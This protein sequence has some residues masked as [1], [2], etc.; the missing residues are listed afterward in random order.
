MKNNNL[1]SS[2]LEKL[3]HKQYFELIRRHGHTMAKEVCLM[4]NQTGNSMQQS[5]CSDN[6]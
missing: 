2:Y 6:Q 1:S 5:V 4:Q 3:T